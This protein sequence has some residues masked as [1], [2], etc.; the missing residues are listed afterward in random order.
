MHAPGE[1]ACASGV[2]AS[3]AKRVPE[4]AH[5]TVGAPG[6]P[7]APGVSVYLATIWRSSSSALTA[8]TGGS[9]NF[10]T[11][12]LTPPAGWSASAL[13]PVVGELLQQATFNFSGA[14]GSTVTATTWNTPTF[15]SPA[16]VVD[17]GPTVSH[18][19]PRV[20]GTATAGIKFKPDGNIARRVSA[21]SS[22]TVDI[23]KIYLPLGG[24]PMASKYIQFTQVSFDVLTGSPSVGGVT[25]AIVQLNVDREVTLSAPVTSSAELVV[26]YKVFADLAGTTLESSGLLNLTAQAEP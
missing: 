21:S 25:G 20:G 2:P 8:P 18:F 24:T 22:S 14:A 17:P 23:A 5:C 15:L 11:G 3:G 1:L 10:A 4:P 6:S 7:G 19:A 12:V 26:R 9:F 13:S 16:G